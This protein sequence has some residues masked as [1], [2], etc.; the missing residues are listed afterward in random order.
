MQEL[1]GHHDW[2]ARGGL[3]GLDT[4]DEEEPD[5]EGAAIGAA[6]DAPHAALARAIAG[7]P[8]P[9]QELH[10]AAAQQ[11]VYEPVPVSVHLAPSQRRVQQPALEAEP[12]RRLKKGTG[13]WLCEHRGDPIAPGH[14]VTVVQACYWL[15]SMK[16]DHRVTDTVIDQFCA[17]M[18][19]LILP[20]D[21]LYPASYHMVKAVLDVESSK[22]CTRHICD[23]CWTVF[24]DMH[25]ALYPG[26]ADAVC[27]AEGCG[28]RRFDVSDTG[29]VLPKRNIYCFDVRSTVLD[30]L[31]PILEDL[32]TYREQR[33]QA[34]KDPASYFRSPAGQYVDA[35]I[36]H[37]LSA[38]S[39]DEI[40]IPF[41]MGMLPMAT[42]AGGD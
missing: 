32:D 36:G 24:P 35:A 7:G 38:P 21:N 31:D 41:T 28:N 27:A 39:E 20:A 2:R 6:V 40:V 15:A 42:P 11:G 23:K 3:E 26:N 12:G 4:D 9:G 22:A 17:M 30:L 29:V 14:T 25:S 37:K 18:H 16:N 5:Q 19:H 34:Y 10:E 33:E 8:V 13:A 1:I